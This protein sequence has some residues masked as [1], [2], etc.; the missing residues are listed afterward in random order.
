[1]DGEPA[2]SDSAVPLTSFVARS[3]SNAA[4]RAVTF[5]SASQPTLVDVE[6]PKITTES[7]SATAKF[8]FRAR[9]L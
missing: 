3:H 1:L 2:P 5:S 4:A 9:L 7:H 6:F 8:S